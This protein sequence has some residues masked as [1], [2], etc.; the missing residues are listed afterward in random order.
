MLIGCSQ[1]KQI[2]EISTL[3]EHLVSECEFRSKFRQ[4]PRCRDAVPTTEFDAHTSARTCKVVPPGKTVCPL[5][6]ADVGNDEEAWLVH[7]VDDGCPA[8]PRTA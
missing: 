5:C 8:N 3:Q 1:C 6:R 4:C 2:I 7:F